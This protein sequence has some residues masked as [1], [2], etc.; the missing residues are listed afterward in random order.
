MGPQADSH[1]AEKRKGRPISD[2]RGTIIDALPVHL[3]Q[4]PIAINGN[5]GF[6]AWMANLVDGESPHFKRSDGIP[7]K[8]SSNTLG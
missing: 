2:V 7:D 6:T 3:L 4:E 8:K 5:A 1:H